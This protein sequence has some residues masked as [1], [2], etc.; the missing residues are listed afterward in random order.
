[1]LIGFPARGIGRDTPF[2]LEIDGITASVRLSETGLALI[3]GDER[4]TQQ[5]V[6]GTLE[7]I[8]SEIIEML[9]GIFDSILELDIL[10]V[11][12]YSVGGILGV[13]ICI[14]Y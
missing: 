5:G 6:F 10:G 11:L 9:D 8:L 2:F 13:V 3:N 4:V 12:E 7:C 14:V 1:V